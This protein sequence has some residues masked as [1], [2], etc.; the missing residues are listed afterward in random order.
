VTTA[1]LAAVPV[2]GVILVL[3]TYGIGARF[4]S[5]VGVAAAALI[6]TSP[7]FRYQVMQPMSDVP[8]AAMWVVAVAA[9]TG[10]RPRSHVA[11]G[12]AASLGIL[13]RP[14]LLPLGL[15]IGVFLLLRPERPRAIRGRAAAMYAAVCAPGCLAAAAIGHSLFE[16]SSASAYG[17]PEALSSL[18]PVATNLRR[19]VEARWSSHVPLIAAVGTALFMLSGPMALF[20]AAM[21]AVNIAVSLVQVPF[22]SWFSL[23]LPLPA[24]PFALVL[25]VAVAD[26]AVTRLLGTGLSP[27]PPRLRTRA[28][29][30]LGAVTFVLALLL[31]V[32]T[33]T[34]RAPAP[35]TTAP[36]VDRGEGYAV[37]P[38]RAGSDLTTDYARPGKR[39]QQTI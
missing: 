1:A 31:L 30:I 37:E 23:P 28:A 13:I 8:A 39:H 26:A 32:Q 20:L 21:F 29:L 2:F 16:S 33:S 38:Y 3:A 10:T 14:D 11:A 27:A 18:G 12:I 15:V 9:A 7:T 35:H 19:Y 5:R 36:H 22:E 24:L 34:R 17:A 4:G 25:L 6:A